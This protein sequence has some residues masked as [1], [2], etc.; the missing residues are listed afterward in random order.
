MGAAQQGFDEAA[1]LVND[2]LAKLTDNAKESYTAATNVVAT[3]EGLEIPYEEI[4]PAEPPTLQFKEIEPEDAPGKPEFVPLVDVP[5]MPHHALKT[6]PTDVLYD[7]LASTEAQVV[8][9]SS[10]PDASS[11][12]SANKMFMQPVTVPRITPNSVPGSYELSPL[13]AP[14]AS[15]YSELPE[16]LVI[17]PLPQQTLLEYADYARLDG[18]DVPTAPKFDEAP[19]A[20]EQLQIASPSSRFT[21]LATQVKA[22]LDASPSMFDGILAAVF[23]REDLL[24]NKA[25]DERKG[26]YDLRG[27]ALP[28][29]SVG[30]LDRTVQVENSYARN[31]VALNNLI[32]SSDWQMDNL[33]FCLAQNIALEGQYLEQFSTVAK[34]T[35]GLAKAQLALDMKMFQMLL[36]AYGAKAKSYAAAVANRE[37]QLDVNQGK[38]SYVTAQTQVEAAKTQANDRRLSATEQRIISDNTRIDLQSTQLETARTQLEV[39]KGLIEQFR[40]QIQVQAANLSLDAKRQQT[41]L[42]AL[43]AEGTKVDALNLQVSLHEA[44][45]K[46]LDAKRRVAE[47]RLNVAGEV[48]EEAINTNKARTAVKFKDHAAKLDKMRQELEVFR[49]KVDDY[50]TKIGIK[51]AIGK[52]DVRVQK[53]KA[54]VA[55]AVFR[56]QASEITNAAQRYSQRTAV[57][58]DA[59][60]AAGATA[61]QLSAGA[62]SALN[63]GAQIAGSAQGQGQASSNLRVNHS[64]KYKGE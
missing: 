16:D 18:V 3:L 11:S 45:L 53:S 32:K 51:T 33:R 22:A 14:E 4:A 30:D 63:I 34:V 50:T 57:V 28:V 19:P 52:L 38:V 44:S 39:A 35:F 49:G 9:R 64:Y 60:T 8:A 54:T 59:L 43:E 20:T 42:A 31:E 56:T 40:G 6:P 24:A 1:T 48:A 46:T 21:I 23:T 26:V 36:T 5:R 27:V 29:E 25:R 55:E 41:I 13:E 17:Q 7:T 47:S 37:A 10:T 2:N 15:E 58:I 61:A 62:L 12:P